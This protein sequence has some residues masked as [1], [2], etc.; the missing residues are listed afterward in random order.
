[1]VVS[2]VSA[3]SCGSC[4]VRGRSR[5]NAK[6]NGIASETAKATAT[7]RVKSASPKLTP[8]RIAQRL[9]LSVSVSAANKPVTQMKPV[10]SESMWNVRACPIRNGSVASKK[11][12]SN[13]TSSKRGRSARAGSTRWSSQ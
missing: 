5:S 13:G 12:A 7:I 11:A 2:A 6:P 10:S 4:F 1:V 9:R 3:N 8:A